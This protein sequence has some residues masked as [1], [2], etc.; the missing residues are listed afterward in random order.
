MEHVDSGFLNYVFILFILYTSFNNE[1]NELIYLRQV[2]LF[3]HVHSNA[4]KVIAG[5]FSK[6]RIGGDVEVQLPS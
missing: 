1:P 6:S 5:F 2:K 3:I 4:H